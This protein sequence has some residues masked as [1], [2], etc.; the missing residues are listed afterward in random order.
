VEIPDYSREQ[1]DMLADY[2]PLM[3]LVLYIAV[4]RLHTTQ[5]ESTSDAAKKIDFTLIHSA[6][7]S[8]MLPC[9]CYNQVAARLRRGTESDEEFSKKVIYLLGVMARNTSF[10]PLLLNFS[11]SE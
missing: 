6:L 7:K 2:P 5:I 8:R 11:F 3:S 9:S 1:L 4:G 10:D